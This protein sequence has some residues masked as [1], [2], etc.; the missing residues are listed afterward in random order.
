MVNRIARGRLGYLLKSKNYIYPKIKESRPRTYS[1][2]WSIFSVHVGVIYRSVGDQGLELGPFVCVVVVVVFN[3][4]P[5]P[6]HGTY[7]S[8]E[9]V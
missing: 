1:Q 3:V 8:G 6:G 7:I 4:F 5:C 9:H 2:T